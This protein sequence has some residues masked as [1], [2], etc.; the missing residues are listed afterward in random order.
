MERDRERNLYFQPIRISPKDKK[1]KLNH[2][3]ENT[4]QQTK[5]LRR[6]YLDKISIF[7]MG[8]AATK[9]NGARQRRKSIISTDANFAQG[10]ETE[11]K[12]HSREYITTNQTPAPQI[13]RQ[14]FDF[15]NGPAATKSNG[16]RQRT[17]SIFSTDTNF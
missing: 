9:S 12:P 2:I 5:H 7:S 13:L 10:Q 3:Q 14:N 8:P 1:Q 15:F 6:K 11:A 16:A 4:L 17:K